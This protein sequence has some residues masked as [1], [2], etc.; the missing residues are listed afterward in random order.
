MLCYAI[1][2]A[3]T[4]LQPLQAQSGKITETLLLTEDARARAEDRSTEASRQV[5]HLTNANAML[6]KRLVE[7]HGHHAHAREARAALELQIE[8]LTDSRDEQ[9]DKCQSFSAAVR[10]Q[11]DALRTAELELSSRDHAL[12][13][14]RSAR[15]AAEASQRA[16]DASASAAH[17]AAQAAAGQL[18]SASASLSTERAAGSGLMAEAELRER[19]QA[20][21]FTVVSELLARVL[22]LGQL[23]PEVLDMGATEMAHH[24]AEA[25]REL[26]ALRN[27]HQLCAS[28]SDLR[29]SRHTVAAGAGV[30]KAATHVGLNPDS[31]RRA[32]ASVVDAATASTAAAIHAGALSHGPHFAP[33]PGRKG[34]VAAPKGGGGSF[35]SP[36]GTSSK[37]GSSAA[38]SPAGSHA[39]SRAAAPRAAPDDPGA[40]AALE[41]SIVG[42]LPAAVAGAGHAAAKGSRPSSRSSRGTSDLDSLPGY[43]DWR[44]TVHQVPDASLAKLQADDAA[45]KQRLRK[46]RLMSTT[47]AWLQ[48]N[49]AS[50]NK[51]VAMHLSNKNVA[52]HLREGQHMPAPPPVGAADGPVT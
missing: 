17:T 47:T 36:R 27:A 23:P 19:E 41:A 14:E 48:H 29:C 21:L 9:R 45:N 1:E 26:R 20:T 7:E 22:Y 40:A 10:A 25:V 30:I 18:A 39:S 49:D 46:Q 13:L 38:G 35:T 15:E 34:G 42:D 8:L 12:R 24:Q 51:N 43:A 31:P 37:H 32:R 2:Q 52:M 50:S 33:A 6:Q 28:L 16:A 5:S 4:T 44:A 3:E 11:S